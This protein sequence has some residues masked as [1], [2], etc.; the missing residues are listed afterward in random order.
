VSSPNLD[1]YAITVLDKANPLNQYSAN[2]SRTDDQNKTLANFNDR[3]DKT[4][5]SI[6][7]IRQ[8]VFDISNSNQ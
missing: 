5:H 1:K 7:I 3:T 8:D 2:T 4:F 6:N